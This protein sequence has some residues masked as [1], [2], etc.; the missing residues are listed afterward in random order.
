MERMA[1]LPL[2]DA[3]L[4]RERALIGGAWV[5]AATWSS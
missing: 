3:E 5:E 1:A 2:E 4:F